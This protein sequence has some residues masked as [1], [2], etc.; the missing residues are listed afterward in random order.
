MDDVLA[1]IRFFVDSQIR[2]GFSSV[3]EIVEETTDFVFETLGRDDLEI[4]V[5]HIVT[6]LL[7][8]YRT[9]QGYWKSSTD[10]DRLNEA[11]A[12]LNRQGI[13]ARQNFSCCNNCGFTEIWDEIDREEKHQPI[14]G[15]VFY[16]LQGTE[17]AIKT[18]RLLLAYGCIEEDMKVLTKVANKIV[19]E[20]RHVGLDANWQGTTSHPIVVDGIVWQRRRDNLK[21]CQ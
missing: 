1:D 17:Q 16:H 8:A 19:E 12:A 18:G 6:D 7:V 4:E 10:C 20:L 13:V 3:H 5:Q 11:F 15:Y 21:L 9:E 14:E 2:Q